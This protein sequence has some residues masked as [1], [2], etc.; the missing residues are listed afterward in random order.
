MLSFAL[1]VSTAARYAAATTA[2]SAQLALATARGTAVVTGAVAVATVEQ[3]G[4]LL[5]RRVPRAAA[6]IP[7]AGVVEQAARRL[8]TGLGHLADGGLHRSTRRVWHEDG[9]AHVEVKGLTGEARGTGGWPRMSPPPCAIKGVRWAEVNAV[10]QHVLVD[11]DE[12]ELDVARSSRRRGRRGGARRRRGDF[13]AHQ[14]RAPLGRRAGHPGRV[15]LAADVVGL[16]SRSPATRSAASRRVTHASRCSSPRPTR[17]CA[18]WWRSGSA[19][20]TPSCC[21]RWP[22][23]PSTRGRGSR[24]DPRGQHR[25]TP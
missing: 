2:A 10:T 17:A 22:P 4:G 20:P 19:A 25:T 1:P 15:S 18:T 24:A 3:A 8:G 14:A 13:A 11:F 21:S 9:R 7:A 23:R 5:A 6:A 16:S 12:E